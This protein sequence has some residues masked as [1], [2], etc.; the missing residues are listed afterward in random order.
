MRID[1]KKF[2]FIGIEAEKEAFFTKAQEKGLV[3]FI[4]T[5]KTRIKEIPLPV[6]H[7]TRAIKILR[8]LPTLEQEEV[9]HLTLSKEIAEKIIQLK[10]RIEDL[11]EEKRMNGLEISRVHI[12]GDFSLKDKEVIEKEGKRKI[13]FFYAK[14][15]FAEQN[16]LPD[17]LLK[18][19]TEYGLDYFVSVAKEDMKYERMSEMLIDTPL[20]ELLN[21]ER[22]IKK[23]L[24][25]SENELK[26]YAKYNRFLHNALID[27]LNSYELTV[28]Q[29]STQEEMQGELFAVEGWA[30]F[31]QIP[32]LHDFVNQMT[33]HIEEVAIEA[34]DIVPTYL[35]NEGI[36]RVGED[37]VHIYDTPSPTDK[38]PSLWVL[39]WF[40]I[41]FAMIIG[42]AG[43]GLVFLGTA[44]YA[45]YKYG[46]LKGLGLRVWKLLLIL[47][48]A[49]VSWGLMTHSFFGYE[50]DTH[51]P[52]RQYS[53][54]N[55]L[56]HKKAEYLLKH[57]E[58]EAFQEWMKRFPALEKATNAQEV[59]NGAVTINEDHVSY[60]MA[61]KFADNILLELALGIGIIHLS[62]SFLRNLRRNSSG[63]G[64]V[65]F[66][67]GCYLYF[68][69]YLEA[70]SIFNFVMNIDPV[71]TAKNG[72]YLIY[73][74]LGLAMGLAFIRDKAWGLLEAMNLIQVFSD[75]LSYLRLY[76]LALAGAIVTT[77]INEFAV[78][79]PFVFGVMLF[80]IGHLTN[81]M[82]GIM[83]GVLHG[84]R[85]N[86]LEWY[87]Y[88]FEGGG[89]LFSPLRKIPLE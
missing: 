81:I 35:E 48:L 9:D 25:H 52:V 61:S 30:P 5:N 38:D 54:M 71:D 37:L 72:L 75:V 84:L 78:A 32:E 62:F 58:G 47:S 46:E 60:E 24:H 79:V 56:V 42:D 3:H 21:R 83:G 44:V 10:E 65:L 8:G 7:I 76:A 45:R 63:I 2:L 26:T 55:W 89:K 64:W 20:G 34:E 36:R 27:Q 12:F 14:E 86:F 67:I 77:T 40:S 19:G 59:I 28:A 57:R 74:G 68:P 22:E 39:V 70:L 87:H 53:P 17:T 1:V 69:H 15:G 11:E 88:S 50:F 29:K 33:I 66:M 49:V 18:I 31:P 80:I 13:Q 41:F 82:L 73:C 4:D 23:E 6:A 43:Y 16:S 51:H 85:L